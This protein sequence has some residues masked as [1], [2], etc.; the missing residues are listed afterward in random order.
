MDK[1]FKTHD[2][3]LEILSSRGLSINNREEAK[4]VL[5]QINYYNLIN[6]YKTPFLE[7]NSLREGEERYKS[8]S[9]F[10]E[11]Y[12]LH[13]M[14][15]ELKEV[16]FFSLLR[17]EKLLKTSCA[18][19]FSYLHREGLYPYLQI[20]NYSSSQHQLAYTLKNIST[21]SNTISRENR[22]SDGKK[23]IKHYIKKHGHIPLWVLVNF[24][25][26]GNISYF[27]SSLDET[28]QNLI[29]R[30]FGERYKKEYCSKE[31]ISKTELIEIIKICN[32]FR[33]V[34]AHDEVMYSFS[35]NKPG[36]TA[37]FKKFFDEKYT[38]KNLYDLLLVLRLVLP[39]DDCQKLIHSILSIKRSYAEAF[40][41]ISV[42]DIFKA[43]GF[44]S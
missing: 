19:H 23:P 35:L 18:Y 31:K 17:F 33:N 15:R 42:D 8:K 3:Q 11:I 25:T 32:F 36:Q 12:A 14:D 1:P 39:K 20:E 2:E 7:V 16:V 38:G 4:I 29:A 10:K 5:A 44:P 40:T 24:L 37:I 27:Y 28:L 9:S 13:E 41:S 26:L 6:G 21:L 30:D 22:N 34:C 43:S